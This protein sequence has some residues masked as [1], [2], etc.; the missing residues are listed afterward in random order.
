MDWNVHFVHSSCVQYSLL[1][2]MVVAL[3]RSDSWAALRKKNAS[4]QN[5]TVGS[6]NN[7][8]SS[9]LN[10]QEATVICVGRS[11]PRPIAKPYWR[12]GKDADLEAAEMKV[13]SLSLYNVII[14][15]GGAVLKAA[16]MCAVERWHGT[17]SFLW[18][19]I[20][21][22]QHSASGIADHLWDMSCLLCWSVHPGWL[23]VCGALCN[24][25]P[26]R[27]SAQ[28][29]SHFCGFYLLSWS[30]DVKEHAMQPESV[31]VSC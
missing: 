15:S 30:I 23:A 9:G 7:Q 28:C 2:Q 25:E 21:L 22:V 20:L 27:P 5:W 19:R 12:M 24:E 11:L 29:Y 14:V 8:C 10:C 18:P 26:T 31:P 1:Q 13:F 6:K 4:R 3:F 16:V 17:S